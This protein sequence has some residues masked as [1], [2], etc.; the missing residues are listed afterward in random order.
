MTLTILPDEVALPQFVLSYWSELHDKIQ[1][2]GVLDV[3]ALAETTLALAGSIARDV[4]PFAL[5]VRKALDL[6]DTVLL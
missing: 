3:F 1:E 6:L 2:A 4:R 5:R